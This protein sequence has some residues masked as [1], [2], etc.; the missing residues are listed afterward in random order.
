[1]RADSA[2]KRLQRPK[3]FIV[4]DD[5]IYVEE[6]S[7]HR[8]TAFRLQPDGTSATRQGRER[9]RGGRELRRP[10]VLPPHVQVRA[11]Q[12]KEQRQQCAA[13][14]TGH[15]LQYEDSCSTRAAN[16]HR[17][18][19]L[20]GRL[21]AYRLKPEPRLPDAPRVRLP[22]QPTFISTATRS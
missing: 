10:R 13:S 2:R 6:R 5:F 19:V 7:I 3:A 20:Q 4:V 9:E 12:A 8:L 21:D 18:A 14:T 22:K 1:M 11:R 15:V 16:A 17:H